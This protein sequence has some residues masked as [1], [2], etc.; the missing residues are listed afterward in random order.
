MI[1]FPRTNC[2]TAL[3]RTWLGHTTEFDPSYVSSWYC[4]QGYRWINS[5]YLGWWI[6][7][8]HQRRKRSVVGGHDGSTLC[9]KVCYRLEPV[10][11]LLV[12]LLVGW[13]HQWWWWPF[14]VA[15][16]TTTC[17]SFP[18]LSFDKIYDTWVQLIDAN[19][20]VLQQQQITSTIGSGSQTF[21]FTPTPNVYAIRFQKYRVNKVIHFA[22]IQAW[23][24]AI[25][26]WDTGHHKGHTEDA[27]RCAIISQI[28]L[29]E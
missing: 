3:D 16:Q 22:E 10:R 9:C 26:P 8:T 18:P 11:L 21:Y 25:P 28:W 15:H 5:V 29:E 6:R 1:P 2:Y 13:I 12:S 27:C 20:S 23:G 19:G 17:C 7:N 4:G 24:Y 14:D